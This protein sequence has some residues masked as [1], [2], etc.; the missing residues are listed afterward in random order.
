M[1]ETERRLQELREW[2]NARTMAEFMDEQRSRAN[3]GSIPCGAEKQGT[4]G[5]YPGNTS[6]RL[7]ESLR[8][9]G[10][11][12]EMRHRLEEMAI[13]SVHQL[14]HKNKQYGESWC[15]RGGEQAF[16][17][18]ARKWD[19]LEAILEQMD[20]GYNIFEAWEKNPGNIRDDIRDLRD[21]LFLLEEFCT[22]GIEGLTQIKIKD[23]IEDP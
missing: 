5:P 15:K 4:G 19:R 10:G 7:E 17:V 16:A 1:D 23:P 6:G 11:T 13:K 2:K 21:Y 3:D 18:I 8:G 14:V 20:N 12:T 22:R 9:L